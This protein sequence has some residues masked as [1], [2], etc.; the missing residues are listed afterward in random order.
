MK[1]YEIIKHS[2][3]DGKNIFE[4]VCEI[5]GERKMMRTIKKLT[6]NEFGYLMNYKGWISYERHDD[7][8]PLLEIPVR[9]IGAEIK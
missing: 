4:A 7:G 1:R 6:L 9:Y 2:I 3:I 8:V 5:K